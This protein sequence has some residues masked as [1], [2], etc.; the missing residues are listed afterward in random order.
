MF[1]ILAPLS[2]NITG[3]F[4]AELGRQPWVVYGLMRTKDALSQSITGG[5][6]LGSLIMFVCIFSLLLVLF[7]FLLNQK[8]QYGPEDKEHAV[9]PYRD[10][11]Q[12]REGSSER[13][14]PKGTAT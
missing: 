13:K 12:G 5:Q 2:A 11:Y 3:W 9:D 1:T 6:V 8:I 7:L 10:P 14:S 4:S